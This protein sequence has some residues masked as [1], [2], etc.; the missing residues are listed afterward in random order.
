MCTRA[1]LA[2]AQC[3][4]FNDFHLKSR[5]GLLELHRLLERHILLGR[6]P[7]VKCLISFSFS[8]EETPKFSNKTSS[9]VPGTLI[10]QR[11]EERQRDRERQR[12]TDRDTERDVNVK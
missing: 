10:K 11:R 3:L 4:P 9:L 2:A 8:K 12:H 5:C 6:K 1:N 7:Q